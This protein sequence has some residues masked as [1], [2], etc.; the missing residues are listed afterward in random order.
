MYC[1]YKVV[2]F[3]MNGTLTV[4]EFVELV[5]GEGVP[6]LYSLAK[7]I[8]LEEAKKRVFAEYDKV[9]EGRIEWYD[10]KYWFNFFGL[11]DGWEALLRS[12]EHVVRPFPDAVHV[13]ET[14]RRQEQRLVVVSNASAEF[15]SI[16]LPASGLRGYF[17]HAFS[18][19]SDFG[20]VKKTPDVY[21]EVCRA[22]G[23]EPHEMVHVGDHRHFDFTAPQE[24]GMTAFYLDRQGK[25]TGEFVVH[26]LVEFCR[27][28]GSG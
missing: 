13:L 18:S 8:P 16:E 10:I 26:S 17:T 25:E 24:L 22:L 12:F 4:S 23:V 11:G 28:L 15:M 20:Q 5:W 6:K 2:S 21:R 27:R 9:G 1:R 3:D 7:N 19:T 14:L